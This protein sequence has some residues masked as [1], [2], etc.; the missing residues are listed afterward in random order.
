MIH[1]QYT[2]RCNGPMVQWCIKKNI[3]FKISFISIFSL[4][5][6]SC[7]NIWKEDCLTYHPSAMLQA[8]PMWLRHKHL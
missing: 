5:L 4:Y 6:Q 2:K 1:N 3:Y 7:N 8:Q